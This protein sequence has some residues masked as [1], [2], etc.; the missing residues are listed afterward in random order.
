MDI[1][2]DYIE[3]FINTY[4]EVIMNFSILEMKQVTTVNKARSVGAT[5]ANNI[6]FKQLPR[7]VD[8]TV[9]GKPT[10]MLMT[11]NIYDLDEAIAYF[12]IRVKEDLRT[13][14]KRAKSLEVLMR[15]KELLD[16]K[17][18]L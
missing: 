9:R 18:K 7:Y 2:N 13:I 4:V 12:N 8:T 10:K 6:R 16:S 17:D 1:N 3:F 14:R 5:L 11:I 15:V